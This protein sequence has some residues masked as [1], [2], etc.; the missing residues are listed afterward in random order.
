M[1]IP[2]TCVACMFECS[3]DSGYGMKECKYYGIKQLSIKEK[4]Q[5]LFGKFFK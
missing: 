5:I 1:D 2:K 4:I 3:C